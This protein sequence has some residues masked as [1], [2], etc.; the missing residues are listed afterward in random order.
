MSSLMYVPFCLKPST[1]S[2][3]LLINTFLGARVVFADDV[4]G[5]FREDICNGNEFPF[6]MRWNYCL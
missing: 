2:L 5:M 4:I 6:L 1:P 3:K